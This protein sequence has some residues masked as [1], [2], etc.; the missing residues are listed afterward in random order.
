MSVNHNNISWDGIQSLSE[1]LETET[2][3]QENTLAYA[4]KTLYHV[5]VTFTCVQANGSQSQNDRHLS[6]TVIYIVSRCCC[7]RPIWINTTQILLWPQLHFSSTFHMSLK[8][9]GPFIN[10]G[11]DQK[12]FK[13]N[14]NSA[15][16]QRIIMRLKIIPLTGHFRQRCLDDNPHCVL[17]ENF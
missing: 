2:L 15:F 5:S 14:V 1:N 10:K 6:Q 11:S 13:G 16:W 4:V 7:N 9:R 12:L 8:C 3:K 17:P